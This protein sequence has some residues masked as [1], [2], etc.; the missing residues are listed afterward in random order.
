MLTWTRRLIATAAALV[1]MPAVA[2]CSVPSAGATGVSV[3]A[4]GQPLGVILM[5]HDHIDGA[6][7]HAD[8]DDPQSNDSTGRWSRTEPLSGFSTWPLA[9]GDDGAVDGWTAEEPLGALDPRTT[10]R[11]YGWTTDH[12]WASASVSFTLAELEDLTPGQVRYEI[13]DEVTTAS[14]EEF[15][16][17]ACDHF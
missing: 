9:T 5:C 3:T 13:G 4:D 16:R 14:I 2:G 10:Y 12:S 1:A 7:L 11:M 17:T 6:T 8:D 15:R